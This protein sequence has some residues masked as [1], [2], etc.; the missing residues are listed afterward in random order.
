MGG[1]Q[2]I[3]EPDIERGIS[4]ELARCIDRVHQL[5][6]RLS[7]LRNVTAENI[8]KLIG[9]P[10]ASPHLPPCKGDPASTCR[11]AEL[12]NSISLCESNFNGLCGELERLL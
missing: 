11:M 8:T 12:V 1:A 5:A 3:P 10:S 9:P 6:E 7:A 4:P 2:P